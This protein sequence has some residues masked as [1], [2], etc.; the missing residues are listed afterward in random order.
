MWLVIYLRKEYL[1]I[2]VYAIFFTCSNAFTLLLVFTHYIFYEVNNSHTRINVWDFLMFYVL[3]NTWDKCILVLFHGIK[4]PCLYSHSIMYLSDWIVKSV[5]E[6]LHERFVF[7][8]KT[9]ES[10][11]IEILCFHCNRRR[12]RRKCLGIKK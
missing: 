7:F 5:S 1:Q 10:S 8:N 2:V 4:Y 3:R 12:K 6:L 11:E 9:F